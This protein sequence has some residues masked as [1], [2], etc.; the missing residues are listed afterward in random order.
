MV[1][2]SKLLSSV[3][4]DPKHEICILS[5]K[6]TRVRDMM[7]VAARTPKAVNLMPFQRPASFVLDRETAISAF[8]ATTK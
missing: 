2:L 8:R 4:V 6:Y 1:Q 3:D 7:R 5:L